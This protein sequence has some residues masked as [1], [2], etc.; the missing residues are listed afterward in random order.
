MEHNVMETGNV[1]IL[2]CG[3]NQRVRLGISNGSNTAV[4]PT[5]GLKTE[6]DSVSEM[7]CI[8]IS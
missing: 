1:Y 2:R 7:L 3:E 4:V 8:F 5:T 6:N